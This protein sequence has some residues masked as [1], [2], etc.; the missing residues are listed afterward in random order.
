MF[1]LKIKPKKLGKVPKRSHYYELVEI[2]TAPAS[3]ITLNEGHGEN[4]ET[5]SADLMKQSDSRSTPAT[6]ELK[7][8]AYDSKGNLPEGSELE[9]SPE[10]SGD[11]TIERPR[12]SSTS[13]VIEKSG[14]LPSALGT[15]E[16][17][18]DKSFETSEPESISEEPADDNAEVPQRLP[19]SNLTKK[20]MNP[21]P[22]S[23][24]AKGENVENNS[25]ELS[26]KGLGEIKTKDNSSG[27]RRAFIA[28]SN[29][30][31]FSS[32]IRAWKGLKIQEKS[33]ETERTNMTSSFKNMK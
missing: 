31:N 1:L 4:S 22:S 3:S 12:Q 17:K 23:A 27:I 24:A 9:F 33:P 6:E 20:S 14:A 15:G 26:A 30:K 21:S 8:S 2:T 10:K 19:K 32:K 18:K 11:N 25:E 29:K 13:E 5:I 16:N 28:Q 7:D